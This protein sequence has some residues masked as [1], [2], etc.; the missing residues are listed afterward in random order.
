MRKIVLKLKPIKAFGDVD[1]FSD[2]GSQPILCRSILAELFTLPKAKETPISVVVSDKK[3]QNSYKVKFG[4]RGDVMAHYDGGWR[5]I[6]MTDE[7]ED[8]A[9]K[10]GLAGEAVWVT[11]YW[12]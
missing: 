8:L 12:E 2:D 1:Y 7:A 11:L 5:Y 9:V 4:G 10:L 6:C 3:T